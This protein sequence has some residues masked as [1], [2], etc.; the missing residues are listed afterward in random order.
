MKM[1]TMITGIGLLLV[2]APAVQADA[3]ADLQAAYRAQGV[4][5]FSAADGEALWNREFTDP[6]SGQK[7]S[8]ASCH[9]ANLR[10]GGE[11]V[12]TGKSI[13]PMAPSVNAERLTDVRKI[14]K[15]F[16]RNC[17]WTLGREC[18]ARE[19]ADVLVFIQNQ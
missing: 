14:E 9:T 2:T 16:K 1:R 5:T 17:S 4:E 6:G 13:A 8:C 12:R 11:H 7:R 18:T 3:V 10:Q 19:K 15:W